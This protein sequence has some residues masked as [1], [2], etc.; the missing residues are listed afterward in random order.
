MWM[1]NGWWRGG[2]LASFRV[3]GGEKRDAIEALR[4]W[5]HSRSKQ[6]RT[7]HI[8]RKDPSEQ[9]KGTTDNDKIIIES[10]T[11]LIENNDSDDPWEEWDRQEIRG[12]L[13][14]PVVCVCCCAY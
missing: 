10:L 2:W 4:K 14:F 7:D 6:T 12:G 8:D 5:S 9:G 11:Y 13:L 1:A 3:V